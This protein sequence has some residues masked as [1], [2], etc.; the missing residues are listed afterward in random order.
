MQRVPPK[1]PIYI[2][3]GKR[4]KW[5]IDTWELDCPCH[6]GYICIS[7][8]IKHIEPLIEIQYVWVRRVPFFSHAIYTYKNKWKLY[9]IDTIRPIEIF[10][11]IS[12]PY[13]SNL[14]VIGLKHFSYKGNDKVK[15][16]FLGTP[17]IQGIIFYPLTFMIE[18]IMNVKGKN[19]IFSYFENI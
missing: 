15:G 19:I 8:Q 7:L 13:I 10:A 17:R 18:S 14:E 6:I 4:K 9:E 3:V 5:K 1:L 2:K 12:G 16:K 11:F